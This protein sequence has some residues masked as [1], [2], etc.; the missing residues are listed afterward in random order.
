[1]LNK[2]T[3]QNSTL[4]SA[5][6]MRH[7][8]V[9]RYEKN[10]CYLKKGN[11]IGGMNRL[12]LATRA[13]I[14]SMLCE[15]SSMRS[16]SR[17]TDV[18]INTVDKLLRDAGAVCAA[19]HDKTV[20]GVKSQ[21]VQCDE[22]WSFCYAKAKNVPTAKRQDLAYGDVWTW[23]ALDADSKLILSWI[24][25]G[26][27]ADYALG[28]MDDLRGRLANR[29]QLTTDGHKAYLEAVEEAFGAD[30]DYAML[31]KL[32]GAPPSSA[33]AARRYSPADCVGARKTPITGNPDPKHVSTSYSERHNLTIRMGMRRF[34]GLTNAFT[35]KVENHC[36]A[37]SLYFVFYNFVRMHKTLRMTP[38]MAA[39]VSDR[40]WSMDDIVALID[41]REDM[42]TG[43]LLV[44]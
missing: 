39:G 1:M 16:I 32:Y 17:V 26:R 29:V 41:R 43:R 37:L 44:G 34:T 9:K 4:A 38:A 23:T 28:L 20:R 21:R 15:G 8:G 33:E 24:V 40:L 27:D 13:Q 5:I 11:Y 18:S 19:F 14:L 6:S 12:S 36:H 31:I 35:K 10:A 3:A 7:L 30:V 22:I 25:G 42:R 2:A